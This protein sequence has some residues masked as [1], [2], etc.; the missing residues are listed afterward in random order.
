MNLGETFNKFQKSIQEG[1]GF[2][3]SK[4]FADDL[5]KGELIC[6]RFACMKQAGS[7]R[8]EKR[9]SALSFASVQISNFKH[10]TRLSVIYHDQMDIREQVSTNFFEFFSFNVTFCPELSKILF[11]PNTGQSG[12]LLIQI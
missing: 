11:C 10:S 9:T 8:Y 2:S 6:S 1:S 12:L 3:F 7:E 5:S 4:L